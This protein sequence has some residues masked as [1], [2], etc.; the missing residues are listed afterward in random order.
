MGDGT[1]LLNPRD[2][3]EEEYAALYRR[4]L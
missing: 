2:V 1:T 3:G 4:A